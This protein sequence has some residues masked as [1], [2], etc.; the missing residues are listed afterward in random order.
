MPKSKK[1]VDTKKLERIYKL[2]ISK[3]IIIDILM[4]LIGIGFIKN[5]Y[6]GIRWGEIIFALVIITN[7]LISVFE[8]ATNKLVP[9]FKL[10]IVY[11]IL[12]S[13]IGVLI[14]TN[15]LSL[16]RFLTIMLGIWMVIS[17]SLKI[18]YGSYLK[19]C[20]EKSWKITITVGILLFLFG[21]LNI[22]YDFAAMTV[23][24]V[25]AVFLILYAIL[26]LTNSFLYK[27]RTNEIIKIFKK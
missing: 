20:N 27:K 9:I 17:G 5:P 6:C 22:L 11:G 26:D 25:A 3:N 19:E 13:A 12:S 14:I 15:P 16:T 1:K 4:V 7:G 21:L 8:G 18:F 2:Y 10:N 23:V 24:Y